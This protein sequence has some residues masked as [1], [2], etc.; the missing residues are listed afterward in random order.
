MTEEKKR[1][2]TIK[3]FVNVKLSGKMTADAFMSAHRDFLR[4]HSFLTPIL[5]AYEQKELL[6]TPTL[7]MMQSA[8]FDHMVENELKTA[9]NSIAKAKERAE[10]QKNHK[11]MP[12][13]ILESSKA[14]VICIYVKGENGAELGT[15]EKI[16]GYKIKRPDDDKVY[17]V[18]TLEETDGYKI[19]ETIKE[20]RP[21]VYT[22]DLFQDANGIADRRLMGFEHSLYAEIENNHGARIK[23][24]VMRGDAIARML[25]KGKQAVCR[26]RGKSTKSLGF[27]VKAHNDRSVGP[28]SIHR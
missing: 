22:A 5:D 11:G 14:Y 1:P 18:D 27:G 3:K 19:I 4:G 15:F 7:Q 28:W 21:M 10:F 13:S 12:A 9:K 16:T 2:M 26:E 6:P 20:D 8:L 25:R 24:I 23:T 17:E